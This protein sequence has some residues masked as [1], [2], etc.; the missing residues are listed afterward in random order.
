MELQGTIMNT[1]RDGIIKLKPSVCKTRVLWVGSPL[2]D[3]DLTLLYG[4]RTI[5]YYKYKA[6]ILYS[7]CLWWLKNKL[8]LH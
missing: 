6:R 7:Y 3:E 1:S 4:Y 2:S 5:S 8:K